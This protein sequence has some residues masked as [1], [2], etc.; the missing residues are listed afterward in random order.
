MN[1]IIYNIY[2]GQVFIPLF[3]FRIGSKNRQRW[4]QSQVL[5]NQQRRL[6]NAGSVLAGSVDEWLRRPGNCDLFTLSRFNSL[7]HYSLCTAY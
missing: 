5:L 4:C 3:V 6:P 2:L 1:C 7:T